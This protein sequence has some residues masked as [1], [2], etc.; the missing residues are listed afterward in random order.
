MKFQ[1]ESKDTKPGNKD[2]LSRCYNCSKF[3]HLAGE[4]KLPSRPKGACF[5][6]FELGHLS[7]DTTNKKLL[8]KQQQIGSVSDL[9]TASDKQVSNVAET[10]LERKKFEKT[11]E[12]PLNIKCFRSLNYDIDVGDT[13]CSS[14]LDTLLDTGSLI[15]F[16]KKCFVPVKC[17]SPY[18]G[19]K[20][21]GINN[22]GL[23]HLGL[24][25]PNVNFE[26]V[27]RKIE[28]IVVPNNTMSSAVVLGRDALWAL[29]L[30]LTALP[31]NE[32]RATKEIFGIDYP[33]DRVI[34]SLEIN[35]EMGSE[36]ESKLK[37][38]FASE[39]LNQQFPES[40]KVRLQIYYR[41]ITGF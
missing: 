7:K 26:D 8:P 40:P 11:P 24:I 32:A 12:N 29:N 3:R 17:I 4:C 38:L 15:S 23:I 41:L 27:T 19:R 2:T 16:I 34:D 25:S 35:P 21:N 37:S 36:L 31:E 18:D 39:Y 22:S 6:S 20:Y 30:G 10:P 9:N 1:I 33:T 28:L 13:C 5:R 14:T